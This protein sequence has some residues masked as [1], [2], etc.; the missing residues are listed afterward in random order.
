MW[1]KVILGLL[2]HACTRAVYLRGMKDLAYH[3]GS[4]LKT[5]TAD[6]LQAAGEGRDLKTS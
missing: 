6:T 3:A 4:G 2:S 5:K 1:G